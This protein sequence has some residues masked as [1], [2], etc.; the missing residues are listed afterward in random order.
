MVPDL[1]AN[2]RALLAY[3]RL[4]DRRLTRRDLTDHQ[5]LRTRARLQNPRRRPLVIGHV[6]ADLAPLCIAPPQP[7]RFSVCARSV[8]YQTLIRALWF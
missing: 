3:R 6:A 4:L 2:S 5:R 8:C 7:Q 1:A